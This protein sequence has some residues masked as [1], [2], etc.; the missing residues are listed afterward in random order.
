MRILHVLDH[1]L[2]LHSGYSFRTIAILREQRRLGWETRQLTTPRHG[3]VSQDVADSEGWQFDR[4][5]FKPN[6][7]TN[8]P[9]LVYVQEMAATTRRILQ[10][11]SEFHP[12]V[13][14]AH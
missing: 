3:R 12:D 7:L 8:L 5:P 14:H 4:T 6:A 9:G 13:I 10:V 1:S 11:A 2:P